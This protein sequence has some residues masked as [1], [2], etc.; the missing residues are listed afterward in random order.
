MHQ[1]QTEQRRN[2]RRMLG[3]FSIGLGLV[4]IAAGDS[5]ARLLGLRSSARTRRLLTGLGIGEIATGVGLL[6]T[7][8]SGLRASVQKLDQPIHVLRSITINCS[9]ETVYRFWRDL[10]NLPLF[11]GHLESVKVENGRSTWRAKAPAGTSIE[12][13]AEVTLDR[14]NEAIGWRSLEDALVPNRGVVRFKP[15]PGERGTEVLVEL[16]YDPPGG[17][18]GAA[19]AKLLGEEPSRQIAGD[20]RRLKQVLETGDVVCSDASI[21]DG[22][23]A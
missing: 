8:R 18:I 20:L 5:L 11:M 1:Q 15:A 17:V 12:W 10:E 19:V 14:P 4:Q 16:K 13:Q 6:G 7:S 23:H 9:P 3:A 21:H 2:Q 22:M